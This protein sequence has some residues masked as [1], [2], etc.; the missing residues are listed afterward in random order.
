MLRDYKILGITGKLSLS[1]HGLEAGVKLDKEGRLLGQG[2]DPL[3]DHGAVDVVVLDDDVLLEDLDRVQLVRALPLGQHH[4][5]QCHH[6][7]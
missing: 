5:R 7:I 3:L 2:Q 1:Y 6:I 4:L